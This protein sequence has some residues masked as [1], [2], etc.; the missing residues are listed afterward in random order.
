M[1]INT[2]KASKI[3]SPEENLEIL[4][5]KQRSYIIH[6]FGIEDGS[7]KSSIET[8]KKFKCTHQNIVQSINKSLKKIGIS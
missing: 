2:R 5:K 4:T 1:F 3:E 7:I 8:A 6:R